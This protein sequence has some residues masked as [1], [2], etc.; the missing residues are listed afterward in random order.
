MK[1]SLKSRIGIGVLT[2][3]LAFTAFGETPN[4]LSLASKA[5]LKPMIADVWERFGPTPEDLTI[6]RRPSFD[7]VVRRGLFVVLQP[8]RNFLVYGEFLG[9]ESG[10][11][12]DAETN[13]PDA[14]VQKLRQAIANPAVLRQV[15][16]FAESAFLEVLEAEKQS[17]AN[18]LV[19]E[20]QFIA[21]EISGR[22]AYDA[23]VVFDLYEEDTLEEMNWEQR[24]IA[25]GPLVRQEWL[26]RLKGLIA[27]IDL[28][29]PAA[30]GKL[31]FVGSHRLETEI[32]Y[33]QELLNCYR[34]HERY[35]EVCSRAISK[36]DSAQHM[37]RIEFV[38]E[39]GMT[40]DQ[41]MVYQFVE[42]RRAEGGDVLAQTWIDLLKRFSATI[43]TTLAEAEQI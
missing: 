25:F 17:I 23:G 5:I 40:E 42:R 30:E 34:E 10:W 7:Q 11:D 12:R 4:V 8:V 28:L 36:W 6:N 20:Q 2:V 26:T 41:L 32:Q 18:L 37:L 16:V 15:Y 29:I 33:H 39:W 9:V 24:F 21:G 19:A 35:S 31:P 14:V 22:T 3:M 27:Y 13:H 43:K 38:Q 1:F